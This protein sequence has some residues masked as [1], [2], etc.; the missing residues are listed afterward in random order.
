MKAELYC[1]EF[2]QQSKSDFYSF[3]ALI[4]KMQQP[5]ILSV[6]DPENPNTI[7]VAHVLW[8]LKQSITHGVQAGRAYNHL[9]ENLV[10]TYWNDKYVT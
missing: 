8:K 7:Q 1:I 6:W 3:W 4:L 2:G 5:I 10:Q 9:A